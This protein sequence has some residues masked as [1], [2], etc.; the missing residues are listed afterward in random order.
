MRILHTIFS[1]ALVALLILVCGSSAFAQ[2]EIYVVTHLEAAPEGKDTISRGM[3]GVYAATPDRSSGNAAA[4]GLIDRPEVLARFGSTKLGGIQVDGYMFRVYGKIGKLGVCVGT[5]ESRTN[6]FTLGGRTINGRE[7]DK[8][9][10]LGYPVAKNLYAGVYFAPELS[11]YYTVTGK[12]TVAI[13][14]PPFALTPD[15]SVDLQSGVLH[16]GSYGLLYSHGKLHAGIDY[17]AY[18]ENTFNRTTVALPA[19]LG[20]PRTVSSEEEFKS[21]RYQIA[22]RVDDVLKNLDATAGYYSS[23]LEGTV[24]RY[25]FNYN[26]L[27]VGVNYRFSP[28][29]QLQLG[30]NDGQISAGASWSLPVGSDRS[31]RNVSLQVAYQRNQ[32]KRLVEKLGPTLMPDP[33]HDSIEGVIRWSF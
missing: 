31:D 14:F 29:F 20:G 26:K 32:F 33:N 10:G 22:V 16:G 21:E 17:R 24:S 25:E 3:G 27:Q 23:K 11:T 1:V 18:S 19:P 9:F 5:N 4:L 30:A 8:V 6:S 13:P 15:F 12:T 2:N 28:A 7:Q